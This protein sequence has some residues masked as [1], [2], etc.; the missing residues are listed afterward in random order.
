MGVLLDRARDEPHRLV[1]ALAP[2]GEHVAQVVE[3][4][5]VLRVPVEHPPER[6]FGG[7]EPAAPLEDRAEQEQ[8]RRFVRELPARR[9][10]HHDR[11]PRPV[12]LAVE[13][14][15]GQVRPRRVPV[16][17]EHVKQQGLAPVD[18]AP[19]SVQVGL[20]DGQG[21]VSGTGRARPREE[22]RR[23]VGTVRVDVGLRQPG[24]ETGAGRH[25]RDG[26][27][28][29][30]RRALGVLQPLVGAAEL[31]QHFGQQPVRPHAAGL[32]QH[33]GEGLDDA[34]V[35]V[36]ALEDLGERVGSAQPFRLQLDQPA[37]RRF[38]GVEIGERD[39]RF[40]QHVVAGGV[41]GAH[42]EQPA[43]H[44]ARA[45]RLAGLQPGRGQTAPDTGAARVQSHGSPIGL[46]RVPP[47]PAPLVQLAETR[48]HGVRRPGARHRV[49]QR[50]Q[51]LVVTVRLQVGVGQ[52]HAR[53]GVGELVPG[54]VLQQPDRLVRRRRPEVEAGQGQLHLQVRNHRAPRLLQVRDRPLDILAGA[55]ARAGRG[56][57][58]QPEHAVGGTVVRL[59][60]QRLLRGGHG[61]PGPAGPGVQ[62]GQ[63]RQRF[64]GPRIEPGGVPERPDGAVDVVEPLQVPADH[65]A[66]V[67]LGARR[68]IRLR[69]RLRGG[70]PGERRR[71]DGQAGQQDDTFRVAHDRDSSTGRPR[72]QD[73]I[74]APDGREA[75]RGRSA[76]VG[77][78][79]WVSIRS[80]SRFSPVPPARRRSPSSTTAPG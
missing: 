13:R 31:V 5:R 6:P 32:L 11:F 40:R 29:D 3:R 56:R 9:L 70:G 60:G 79:P 41:P 52:Q 77:A 72:R 28:V 2:V 67:R 33:R 63:L 4:L 38:G 57:V 7:G 69:R 61:V 15:Q 19:P 30:A 8:D 37:G 25:Q 16:V 78:G 64:A 45:G 75:R 58:G 47:A 66:G 76:I 80:C 62:R 65:E 44:V 48:Q 59:A 1:E 49:L 74:P 68:R 14:R 17:R 39:L 26:V 27:L 54:Q 46:G 53:P 43:E 35:L 21:Q 24:L 71:R 12:V 20:D 50:A 73:E 34:P 22:P 23:G 55:V 36:P 51:R 42:L 10:Q 18:V